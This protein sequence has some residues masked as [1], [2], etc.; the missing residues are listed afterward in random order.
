MEVSNKTLTK[1]RRIVVASSNDGN[2]TQG[3]NGATTSSRSLVGGGATNTIVIASG[4]VLS[5]GSLP[6]GGAIDAPSTTTNPNTTFEVV[7][8][9]LFNIE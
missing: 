8:L 4:D 5:F 6:R 3:T 9:S 7:S 1:E 2:N